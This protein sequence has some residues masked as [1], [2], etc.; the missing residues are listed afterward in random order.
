M[1]KQSSSWPARGSCRVAQP[2]NASGLE[3]LLPFTPHRKRSRQPLPSARPRATSCCGRVAASRCTSSTIITYS[4]W[5]R[6]TLIRSL[7]GRNDDPAAHRLPGGVCMIRSERDL[8]VGSR[9]LATGRV[10]L[11][12]FSDL[13]RRR[14]YRRSTRLMTRV[15]DGR[16]L[17]ARHKPMHVCKPKQ[18]PGGISKAVRR[19]ATSSQLCYVRSI[20]RTPR[21]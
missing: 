13:L 21:K 11:Y 12:G 14:S 18:W 16:S 3:T 15:P 2:L 1:S 10:A 6:R 4:S 7:L 19:P 8:L 17:D 20:I 5:I 9:F